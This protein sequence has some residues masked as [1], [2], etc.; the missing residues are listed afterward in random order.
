M[1]GIAPLVMRL[2]AVSL[3]A[4]VLAEPGPG[5]SSSQAVINALN[6]KITMAPVRPTAPMKKRKQERR[7]RNRR[8]TTT[9]T[10]TTTTTEMYDDEE[11]PTT[12]ATTTTV[13]PRTFDHSEFCKSIYNF[14]LTKSTKYRYNNS[15][16]YRYI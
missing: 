1:W 3:V 10:T 4:L 11:D 7:Q 12:P 8:R 6:Q 2:V 14:D 15:T 13:D 16:K 5:S 9:T